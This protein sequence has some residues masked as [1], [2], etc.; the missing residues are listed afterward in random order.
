MGFLENRWQ[1]RSL[2]ILA[3]RPL[4]A[5]Y[6]LV[7]SVRN[8]LYD[9]RVLASARM[10][11]PVI[12]VGNITVG[13]TGKTP[14]VAWL[15]EFL[16]QSGYRPGI[17][18]RG[19]R[20]R[21]RVW[22]QAVSPGSDP[23]EVGDEPVLLAR[24]ARCPV[25]V[26][27]DRVAAARALLAAH[28]CDVLISDDGLQHRRLARDIEIVV[29]DGERRFGNGLCL[30]AGPLREPVARLMSVQARVVQGSPRAGETGMTFRDAGFRNLATGE[31]RTARDFSG[32]MELHAV[33]GI[34]NPSRFFAH[35]RNLG[36]NVHEHAYPDHHAF[37]TTDL[38]FG[39]DATVIMTEKDAVKCERFAGRGHW[40][41][42]IEACPDPRLGALILELLKEK[43][44]G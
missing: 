27:P 31:T 34:G 24:H 7:I 30:P 29:I 21:A 4:S 10:P 23:A 6:C 38:D 37:S 35:L 25:M 19:Y 3:L 9:L 41:L 22:P 14:L 39:P 28:D 44:G 40:F 26:G 43:H 32:A 33:A 15:G 36:L 8:R 12:V 20:G 2:V 1:G 5:L 42:S 16:R 18:S 17:V 13:G 11:V